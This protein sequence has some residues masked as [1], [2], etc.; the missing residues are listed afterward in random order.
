MVTVFQQKIIEIAN[1]RHFIEKDQKT[2][3][4]LEV[5]PFSSLEHEYI[6]STDRKGVL[7]MHVSISLQE[8]Q[9]THSNSD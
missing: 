6:L 2:G 3:G 7:L 9:L 5:V 4:L 8:L 1:N